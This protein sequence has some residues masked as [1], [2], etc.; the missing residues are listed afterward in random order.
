MAGFVRDNGIGLC[1][2]SLRSL[3]DA[4]AAVTPDDY[5]RMAD[6]VAIVSRRIASGRYLKTALEKAFSLIHNS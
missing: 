2:D 3:D 1:V 6:N 5:R 4:L